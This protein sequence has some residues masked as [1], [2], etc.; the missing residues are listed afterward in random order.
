MAIVRANWFQVTLGGSSMGRADAR[1]F[2][3]WRRAG[4][5]IG[6]TKTDLILTPRFV[7]VVGRHDIEPPHMTG[8]GMSRDEER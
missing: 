3:A 5:P 7:V 4:F 6:L 1:D 2:V 8:R